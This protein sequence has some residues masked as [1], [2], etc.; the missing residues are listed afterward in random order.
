MSAKEP[1][2]QPFSMMA[3]ARS[4]RYAFAGWWYVLRTQ[5]NAWIHGVVSIGVVLVGLWLGLS[6]TDWAILIITITIVWIAEFMNTALE[7]IIDMLMP[8][9]HPLAKVAKDVAAATVLV[10]A[11]SSVLVGLLILGPPLWLR[12]TG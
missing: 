7:A 8:D 4:F 10:G 5:Q 3:R 9:Y 2:Q 6:R 12:L 1:Q 11:C